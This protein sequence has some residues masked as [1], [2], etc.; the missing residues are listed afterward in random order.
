MSRW[1]DFCCWMGWHKPGAVRLKNPA[2]ANGLE[3]I[4][5]RCLN[6][7]IKDSQGNWFALSGVSGKESA[8]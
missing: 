7:L 4:C 1:G 8:E 6:R 3:T 2:S 5:L